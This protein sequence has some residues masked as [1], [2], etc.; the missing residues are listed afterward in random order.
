MQEGGLG[1]PHYCSCH[2]GGRIPQAP[3]ENSGHAA[4]EGWNETL[5][6]PNDTRFGTSIIMTERVKELKD[7]LMRVVT[8]DTYD[9]YIRSTSVKY[10][11]REKGMR[12]K[13]EILSIG[14]EGDTD[15]DFW[16]EV[17]FF[18][19]KLLSM[20][21]VPRLADGGKPCIAQVFH[22]F[23]IS[24]M[25]V[26][27]LFVK[28][29]YDE[30]EDFL[31]LLKAM[32]ELHAYRVRY[33]A[34]LHVHNSLCVEP[35]I[36]PAPGQWQ[37]QGY[38]CEVREGHLERAEEDGGASPHQTWKECGSIQGRCSG[39]EACKDV[40][41]SSPKGGI[42]KGKQ[43]TS[44]PGTHERLRGSIRRIPRVGEGHHPLRLRRSGGATFGGICFSSDEG[45]GG[46]GGVH[47]SA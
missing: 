8:S 12:T 24:M 33:Y 37:S 23:S 3:P 39:R 2:K 36:S 34:R 22:K 28:K 16:F 43:Y 38:L 20:Y 30:H 4:S 46:V 10:E 7:I 31:Q 29:G 47:P 40:A 21:Y 32:R 42:R 44:P 19:Q 6:L 14:R 9:Q 41:W 25:D 5:L 18:L 35:R 45:G 1:C 11:I 27:E 26:E 15:G 17:D 13:Q